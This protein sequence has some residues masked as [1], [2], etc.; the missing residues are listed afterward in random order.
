MK[1]FLDNLNQSG[2]RQFY[3]T[4]GDG[5]LRKG[6]WQT[7]ASSLSGAARDLV[8]L[9]LL[10]EPLARNKTESLVGAELAEEL[11]QL[12][13]LARENGDYRSA[14]F[15]LLSC[16]SYLF[17]CQL[18]EAPWAYFGEDSIALAVLQTPAPGGRVLDLCAG[19]GIQSFVA[20]GHA[21]EVTGVEVRKEASRVAELNRRLNGIGD[22]LRFVCDAAENFARLEGQPYDRI[23]FNPPLVPTV[24]GYKYAF[25]GDGGVNGLE[26]SERF[27][28]LFHDRLSATGAMEFIGMGLGTTSHAS[29]VDEI[30][31]LA[32][33]HRLTGRVHLLS[34][35][36]IR[37]HSAMFEGYATSLAADN[38]VGLAAAR[39]II[40]RH[41]AKLRF[42]TYWLFFAS[43]ERAA[44]RTRNGLTTVDLTRSFW[45]GWF[46]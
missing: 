21:A 41:Y 31:K 34:Q 8:G 18:T 1:S 2:Y 28:K 15:L 13:I 39:E 37:P 12:G 38:G 20:S 35:H 14:G 24:P 36:P 7:G 22:R 16:R 46:V 9:F 4:F 25:V 40:T 44:G 19:P 43:L 26:V 29:V 3:L 27:I 10:G 30:Q 32:R 45:G 17:F 33:R 11:A 5:N 6:D 23:L 42:D